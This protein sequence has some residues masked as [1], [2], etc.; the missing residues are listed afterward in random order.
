MAKLSNQR[1]GRP[2]RL[3]KRL[4]MQP[5]HGSTPLHMAAKKG[6]HEVVAVLV[7]YNADTSIKDKDKNTAFDLM[8]KEYQK[9]LSLLLSK[10]RT[11]AQ[12][13]RPKIYTVAELKLL[14]TQKRVED[15]AM[16]AERRAIIAEERAATAEETASVLEKTAASAE[17]RAIGAERRATRCEDSKRVAESRATMYEEREPFQLR[18][19]LHQLNREPLKLYREPL[20]LRAKQHQLSREP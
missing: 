7:A 6:H 15:R 18:Q 9:E 14:T 5:S 20:Q 12:V 1:P 16:T 2:G 11:G 17:E 8:V 3:C 13:Q 19:E 4:H 10:T